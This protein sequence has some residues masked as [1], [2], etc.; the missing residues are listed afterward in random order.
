[1]Q[2]QPHCHEVEEDTEEDVE[3]K[4]ERHGRV[5]NGVC[6]IEGK[7]VSFRKLYRNMHP[8][9]QTMYTMYIT[10][11]DMPYRDM[12]DEDTIVK[13]MHVMPWSGSNRRPGL[14][15][16]EFAKLYAFACER[17]MFKVVAR[18]QDMQA[19]GIDNRPFIKLLCQAATAK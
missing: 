1:M 8:S 3:D 6:M 16:H 14:E 15:L 9:A 13:Y 4:E 7:A 5:I 11:N 2:G 17:A 18:I 10:L 12:K 19:P